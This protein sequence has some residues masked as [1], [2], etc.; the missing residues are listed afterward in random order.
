MMDLKISKRQQ[1][2]PWQRMILFFRSVK[3]P[4]IHFILSSCVGVLGAYLFT[5]L[6]EIE[7]Q[8]AAGKIFNHSL[9]VRYSILSALMACTHFLAV[10]STW[11]KFQ[12]DRR[13][14]KMTFRKILTLPMNLY[15]R[16]Q[17]SQLISRVTDDPSMAS[18]LINIM[19]TLVTDVSTAVMMVIGMFQQNLILA[20][21]TIPL[22][23]VNALA[24]Y[25]AS[26]RGYSVGYG[27]QNSISKMLAFLAERSGHIAY[28]KAAGQ[29]EAEY[30]AGVKQSNRWFNAEVK[31][32]FLQLVIDGALQMSTLLLNAGVLIGGAYLASRHQL[33]MEDLISFYIYSAYLPST[34]Q[35]LLCDVQLVKGYQ[36]SLDVITAVNSLPSEDVTSGEAVL[37]NLSAGD[38][39]LEKVSFAYGKTQGTDPEIIKLLDEAN[40][41]EGERSDFADRKA[42]FE[43]LNVTIPPGKTTGILGPSGS[44][45]S[46]LLKILMQMLPVTEG[47]VT[48]QGKDLSQFQ[49][50]DFRHRLAY[51]QQNAPLLSGTIRDNLLY[52]AKRQYSDEEL[53]RMCQKVKIYDYIQS[54][55]EGFDSLVKAKASNMSGGQAQRLAIARALLSEPEI[56]VLDEVTSSL[57]AENAHL[58]ESALMELTKGMTVIM[59]SHD[60]RSLSACDHLLVINNGQLE[61]EGSPEELGKSDTAYAHFCRLQ[62]IE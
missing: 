2:R 48:F 46:T 31:G 50:S 36:G 7:G 56:L 29:E 12:F 42:I 10:Y 47:Q 1:Y 26:T 39:A 51:V 11:V 62:G 9:I 20:S 59:I 53:A 55:P 41:D 6:P 58:V 8:I 52:G 37:E 43:D 61:A 30:E 57:D 34:L 25:Y 54:L 17:P 23:I 22:F 45:K 28:I 60:V 24:L 27:I 16:F 14:Q 38:L 5:T 13:F 32:I 18:E 19:T 49:L 4:W 3:L 33:K 15:Q 40:V 21:L 44:G 35:G